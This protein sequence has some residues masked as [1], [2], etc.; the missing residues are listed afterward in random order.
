MDTTA[1]V[2]SLRRRLREEHGAVVVPLGGAHDDEASHLHA[3]VRLMRELD[4][5]SISE[6]FDRDGQPARRGG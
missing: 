5:E 2:E 3:A 4:I 6:A 1:D